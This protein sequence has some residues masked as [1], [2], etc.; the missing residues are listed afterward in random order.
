[1]AFKVIGA[2]V[3]VVG[4]LVL[5]AMLRPAP[6]ISIVAVGLLALRRVRGAGLHR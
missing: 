6:F 1:M 5:T 4:G 2:V 3:G